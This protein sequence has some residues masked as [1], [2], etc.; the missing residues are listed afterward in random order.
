MRKIVSIF[1]VSLL[2]QAGGLFRIKGKGEGSYFEFLLPQEAFQGGEA[3][4][5]GGRKVDLGELRSRGRLTLKCEEGEREIWLEPFKSAVEPEPGRTYT[6]FHL[7]VR[8]ESEISINLPLWLLRAFLW[9][10]PHL[11]DQDREGE[12]VARAV[13]DFI[14]H[15][16][17]YLGG[18]VGPVRF[19]YFKDEGEEVEIIFR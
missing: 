7:R 5:I 4:S 11:E 13:M 2:L 12:A 14:K 16:E 10:S 15:P 9:F 3:V 8:G 17:T 19:L 1:I 18:Y 6:K